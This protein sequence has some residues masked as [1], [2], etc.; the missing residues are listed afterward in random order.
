LCWTRQRCSKKRCIP[1]GLPCPSTPT[2]SPALDLTSAT[3]TR[4]GLLKP[5]LLQFY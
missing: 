2:A 5:I 1:S 3:P 4:E